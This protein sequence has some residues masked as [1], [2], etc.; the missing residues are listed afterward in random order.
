MCFFYKFFYALQKIALSWLSKTSK[1]K[2]FFLM[3][4]ARD[5]CVLGV[6]NLKIS[7]SF[8]DKF[9]QINRQGSTQYVTS[10]LHSFTQRKQSWQINILNYCWRTRQQSHHSGAQFAFKRKIEKAN[11]RWC[12]HFPIQPSSLIKNQSSDV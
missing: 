1:K 10:N 2:W 9:T 6:N 11:I 3:R 12:V 4:L 7:C 5:C 8:A